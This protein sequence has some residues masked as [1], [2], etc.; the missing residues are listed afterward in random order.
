MDLTKRLSEILGLYLGKK[1]TSVSYAIMIDSEIVAADSL[2]N[3]GGKDKKP[4]TTNHTYNVCSVSK[5]FCTTAVMQLVEQGK[6]DLD[7]PVCHYLPRF[8]M[9]DPRYKDITV[10][11]CLNHSSG[12]PGTQWKHFSATHVGSADNNEY[13]DEV[14]AYLAKSNLKADP[15]KYSAYCNDGFTL[16]EMVVAEVSGMPFGEYCKKYITEPIGAHS[17]RVS[18]TLNPDYPLVREGEKPQELLYLQ[19]CGGFTTTMSDLCRFGNLFL[20]K[21]DVI[22]EES[23]AEMAKRQGR[24]FLEDDDRS[25]LFGLGWDNVALKDPLYDLGEDTH[26]KSGNSFQFDTMFYV[27]PK[28]NAVLAISETH[29]CNLDVGSLI[30]K[31]FG[32]TMLETKGINIFT[33]YK[34]V[35]AELAEKFGGT[36]LV[37]SGAMKTH[38][39]G[40][41][42]TMTRE[43][44]RGNRSLSSYCDLK[45]DGEKFVDNEGNFYFFR[46]AEGNKFFFYTYQGRRIPAAQM[47]MDHPAISE[48]WEKRMGKKYI[49]ID[50]PE[51]DLVGNEIMSAFKLS[52]LPDVEGVIIA[53]FS[54]VATG[55]EVYGIFEAAVIP[56]TEDI[57]RGFIQTPGNGSRDLLDPCFEIV[58]G[59]EYCNVGSYYYR[60]EA[61]LPNY[62]GQNFESSLYGGKYNSVYKITSEIKELPAIPE[63]HRI[64]VMNNDMDV[65]YD[66]LMPNEYSAVSEGYISL[67]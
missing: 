15:G 53:C 17:T 31:M 46:E 58:D 57:A 40:T 59:I 22:S 27:I 2:G 56:D 54:S 62:E 21:N 16:A 34:P 29:D 51:N 24:T 10:R 4:A 55:S 38:F 41:Y 61:T 6:V 45:F 48:K 32:V 23:K 9:L 65:V 42:L 67:I 39:F 50:I 19:G 7:T 28:Y 18:T 30:L 5:V 14:Y 33:K 66:S 43:N 47:A 44:T 35:P 64:I 20:V 63:N 60:D 11:H 49:A 37:P 36:Y 52:K 3:E 8:K 12:M 26:M 13:Y 1:Y 25:K